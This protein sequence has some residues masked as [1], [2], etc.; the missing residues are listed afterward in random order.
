M[1]FRS[2]FNAVILDEHH[3]VAPFYDKYNNSTWQLITTKAPII[4]GAFDGAAGLTMTE[5]DPK[6]FEWDGKRIPLE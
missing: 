6:T 2:L 5:V 1:L 3:V 4:D